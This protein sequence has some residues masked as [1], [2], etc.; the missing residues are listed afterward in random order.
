MWHSSNSKPWG[1]LS[2]NKKARK[3]TQLIEFEM[4][5][6][7]LLSTSHYFRLVPD[8]FHDVGSGVEVGQGDRL[9][10]WYKLRDKETYRAIYGDFSVKDLTE[11]DLPLSLSK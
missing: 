11:S 4:S 1:R 2:K 3:G 5:C 6:V 8:S 9:V 7:P 10:C